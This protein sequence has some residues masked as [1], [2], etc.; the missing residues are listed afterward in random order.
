MYRAKLLITFSS[1]TCLKDVLS[2]FFIVAEHEKYLH[3]IHECSYFGSTC[4]CVHIQR[5]RD[6]VT[7]AS[8]AEE[9]ERWTQSQ[10][11]D[12]PKG[13]ISLFEA[14][15]NRLGRRREG[16]ILSRLSVSKI[17]TKDGEG[18]KQTRSGD[19]NNIG[20]TQ[21]KEELFDRV[22]QEPGRDTSCMVAN[23]A[24]AHSLVTN[25]GKISVYLNK[26]RRR[27]C[28]YI[29]AGRSWVD[30]YQVRTIPVQRECETN[31]KPILDEADFLVSGSDLWRGFPCEKTS[32]ETEVRNNKGNKGSQ[33]CESRK[34]AI[35]V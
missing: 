21:D 29:V 16:G 34:K 12:V 15:N 22:R 6:Y 33:K 26:G 9:I 10:V 19:E 23:H 18:R 4:R 2:D 32:D 27:I 28:Q 7:N 3:V 13:E 14:E 20:E 1:V 8:S 30:G 11:S 31:Q 35:F 17:S 5:L 25:T 24:R